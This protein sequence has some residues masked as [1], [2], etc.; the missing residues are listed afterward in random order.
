MPLAATPTSLVRRAPSLDALGE[1]YDA[2]KFG[3]MLRRQAER[4]ARQA[5]AAA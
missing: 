3:P 4:I 1:L 2:A 5:T